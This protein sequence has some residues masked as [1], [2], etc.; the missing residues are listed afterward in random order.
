VKTLEQRFMELNKYQLREAFKEYEQWRK[1][2]DLPDG[3][4]RI[5]YNQYKE[6]LGYL[7]GANAIAEPFLYVYA[8][9]VT[10]DAQNNEG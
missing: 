6:D 7:I 9:K 8:K 1:T 2:G 3:W 4:L 5:I 10:E